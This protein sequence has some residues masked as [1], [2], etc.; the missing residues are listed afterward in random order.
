MV[1]TVKYNKDFFTKPHPIAR[2][3]HG[4]PAIMAVV[5][6]M[7]LTTLA[8]GC[9]IKIGNNVQ[10]DTTS[11]AESVQDANIPYGLENY[12]NEHPIKKASDE[13]I[14]YKFTPKDKSHTFTL[15]ELWL[16]LNKAGIGFD[17]EQVKAEIGYQR[18]ANIQESSH[19][20]TISGDFITLQI[21][22]PVSATKIKIQLYE[23]YINY[24]LS[25]NSMISK[26]AQNNYNMARYLD[27]YIRRDLLEIQKARSS[28]KDDKYLIY[29]IQTV[30]KAS[31]DLQKVYGETINEVS[32]EDFIKAVIKANG[33]GD[34]LDSNNKEDKV[35]QYVA[36]KTNYPLEDLKLI[37]EYVRKNPEALCYFERERTLEIGASPEY[38]TFATIADMLNQ[39]GMITDENHLIDN[40]NG[41]AS[42]DSSEYSTPSGDPKY[43]GRMKYDAYV[44]DEGLDQLKVLY[45]LYIDYILNN[46][47]LKKMADTMPANPGDEK[48]VPAQLL[49]KLKKDY[50][51]AKNKYNTG[52]NKPCI[53][54]DAYIMS[55]NKIVEDCQNFGDGALCMPFNYFTDVYTQL[56]T[57]YYC[58]KFPKADSTIILAAFQERQ[59]VVKDMYLGD[60][61]SFS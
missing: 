60:E 13:T 14:E 57:G 42:G 31:N 34:I 6:S 58:Q 29:L 35:I 18:N 37:Y 39:K 41:Y 20:V 61:P 23:G 49:D 30:T 33:L 46:S 52:P 45:E 4:N 56:L 44:M 22:E 47:P 59:N 36:E 2:K 43:K 32:L 10:K 26:W 53:Y 28:M 5:G 27:E 50:E 3:H 40:A 24:L 55:L 38:Y 19:T 51:E 1:N 7:V 17:E 15:E 48:S 21:K 16:D 9:S 11:Y 54:P 12:L 25:E 8:T